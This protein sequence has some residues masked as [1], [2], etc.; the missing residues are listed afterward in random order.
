MLVIGLPNP[1]IKLENVPNLLQ[2]IKKGDVEQKGLAGYTAF[3]RKLQVIERTRFH[4]E[5]TRKFDYKSQRFSIEFKH[6]TY[7]EEFKRVLS[8]LFDCKIRVTQTN[9]KTGPYDGDGSCTIVYDVTNDS[10][11]LQAELDKSKDSRSGLP[12]AIL[13]R[14]NRVYIPDPKDPTKWIFS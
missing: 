5:E 9:Q 10:K 3:F 14:S 11:N 2:L 4:C 12:T 7:D 6:T 13:T 1:K 8:A